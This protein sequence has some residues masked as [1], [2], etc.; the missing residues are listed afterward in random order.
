MKLAVKKTHEHFVRRKVDG[1]PINYKIKKSISAIDLSNSTID[2]NLKLLP[3]LIEQTPNA[4][5]VTMNDLY[6]I[7]K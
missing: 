4:K 6:N 7:N 2:F 3:Y 5:I 1:G